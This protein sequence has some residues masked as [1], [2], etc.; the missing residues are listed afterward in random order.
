MPQPSTILDNVTSVALALTFSSAL[1]CLTI[2]AVSS[3]QPKTQQNTY[4]SDYNGDTGEID[5][6]EIRQHIGE[7]ILSEDNDDDDQENGENGKVSNGNSVDDFQS[8]TRK[9]LRRERDLLTAD[10]DHIPTAMSVNMKRIN[11]KMNC[12]ELVW[13]TLTMCSSESRRRIRRAPTESKCFFLL[14]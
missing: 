5:D 12:Y 6:W 10:S 3:N 4:S 9:L 14:Y 2:L 7:N 11:R 1:M 13:L 8:T